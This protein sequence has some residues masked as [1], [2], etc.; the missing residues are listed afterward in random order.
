MESLLKSE[1]IEKETS[2]R[3][4]IRDIRAEEELCKL[5]ILEKRRRRGFRIGP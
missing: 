4:E 2:H 5:I 3:E 1:K